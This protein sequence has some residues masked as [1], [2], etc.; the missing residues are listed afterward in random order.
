MIAFQFQYVVTFS[1]CRLRKETEKLWGVPSQLQNETPN[2]N[3]IYNCIMTP[4]QID[5]IS[6][7]VHSKFWNSSGHSSRYRSAPRSPGC[8]A[9][10]PIFAAV[11]LVFFFVWSKRAWDSESPPT[12]ERLL[13]FCSG[14]LLQASTNVK[15][16][17]KMYQLLL[18]VQLSSAVRPRALSNDF[19]LVGII[20]TNQAA[21]R[22]RA[23]APCGSRAARLR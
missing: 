1:S 12:K 3:G 19:D 20:I 22:G 10:A 15:H 18:H 7:L 2:Y 11:S 14:L 13:D 17:L 23:E 16:F 6:L 9:A 5:E 8:D 4:S 21:A